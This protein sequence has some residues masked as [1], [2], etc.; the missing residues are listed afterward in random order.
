MT[1]IINIHDQIGDQRKSPDNREIGIIEVRII[2]V[3]LYTN[4]CFQGKK[5]KLAT[6]AEGEGYDP[7]SVSLS[8][9]MGTA[10]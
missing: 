1:Y 4:Y 10:V 7:S 6:S 9:G 3:P 5:M 8:N 2:E